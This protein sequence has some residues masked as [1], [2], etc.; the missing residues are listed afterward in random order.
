MR[1]HDLAGV[2][3]ALVALACGG[4]DMANEDNDGTAQ[5]VTGPL[6]RPGHNCL[7]CHREGSDTGA[8]VWSAAGTVFAHPDSRIDG[9]LEG[10]TVILTDAEGHEERL[11]TNAAGNFW[12][13]RPLAD[14]F[15]AALEYEDQRIEMPEPPPAGSCNACHALPPIAGAPG[16]IYAPGG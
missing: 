12:T 15:T 1:L 5:E 6:M 10:V 11:V 9:G 2:P 14:P 13:A 4:Q 8:P 7:S 16:R 3:I